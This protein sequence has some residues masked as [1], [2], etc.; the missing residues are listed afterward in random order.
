MGAEKHRRPMTWSAASPTNLQHLQRSQEQRY[1]CWSSEG[2]DPEHSEP[3]ATT[4]VHGN[5]SCSPCWWHQE[6]TE[7]V[8]HWYFS[9]V[10][11]ELFFIVATF[12]S[13]FIHQNL[14]QQLDKNHTI[15]LDKIQLQTAFHT[16]I[17]HVQ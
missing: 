13:S 14:F 6:E 7:Q 1:W 17:I 2:K 3:F 5:C 12:S 8:L 9:T 11:K 15:K 4:A 10:P 16:L